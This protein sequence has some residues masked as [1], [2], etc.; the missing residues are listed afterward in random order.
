MRLTLAILL[1]VVPPSLMAQSL[2]EWYRVYT[3]D[4]SSIDVNT[5]LMTFISD[6]IVRV[7]FRWT[8]DQPELL[9]GEPKMRYKSRLEVIELNCKLQRYRPYHTTFFDVTGNV[10]RLEDS[11]GRWRSTASGVVI[12]KLITPACE[13]LKKKTTVPNEASSSIELERAAQYAYKFAQRLE[14]SK[15]FRRLIPTFFVEDYL[16]RYLQDEN[17]NWLFNLNR[18]TATKVSRQE[19]QRF[20]VAVM[21]TG[22]LSTLYVLS[23]YPSNLPESVPITKLFSSD[24]LQV[25]KKHPYTTIYKHEE[26]DYGFLAQPVE[27]AR[28]LRIYT[29]LLEKVGSL[30]RYHALRSGSEHS[31]QYQAMLE[32]WDLYEPKLEICAQS[33][34]GLPAG[35]RLFAVNVPVFRLQL[36]EIRGA[37]KVVSAT[38]SF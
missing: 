20:Y 38:S 2:P 34:F 13:L 7:R 1:I 4:E 6:D 10:V 35:T 16:D 28:Q 22:Y 26:N 5:S 9:P 19:L 18:D 31:K 33:C 15:D 30:L 21:N 32:S 24:I 23:R 27:D 17:S 37:L 25:I 11:P 29:D 12:Q 8:F 36:A 3:F 14:Q